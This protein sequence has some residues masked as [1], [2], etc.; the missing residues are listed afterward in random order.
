VVQNSTVS[1]PHCRGR[2]ASDP[3]LAGQA[4]KCPHCQTAFQMPAPTAIPVRWFVARDRQ[5]KGPF[6]LP[7][8][9]Q[10]A[11]SGNLHPSDMLLEDGQQQ[12]RPARD[13]GGLFPAALSVG[14][15]TE[16]V[17]DPV[18]KGR[19]GEEAGARRP[20]LKWLVILTVPVFLVCFLLVGLVVYLAGDKLNAGKTT[21]EKLTVT[22]KNFKFPPDHPNNWILCRYYVTV[23]DE[24]GDRKTLCV[25]DSFMA[26]HFSPED[27]YTNIEIGKTYQVFFKNG[28][29]HFVGLT[30]RCRSHDPKDMAE[31]I[32]QSTAAEMQVFDLL[33]EGN[34]RERDEVK[35]RILNPDKAGP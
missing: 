8:L 10:M 5:K 1:C 7:Q 21:A 33:W 19:S 11:T 29:H 13:M 32:Q 17:D 28:K 14:M 20:L 22:D 30:P 24:K 9:Q 16:V 23:V 34:P 12:W 6:T 27:L 18:S 3:R 25:N 4:V 26:A 35:N 15:P 31:L 2:I